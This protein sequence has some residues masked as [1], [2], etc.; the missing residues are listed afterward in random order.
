MNATSIKKYQTSLS[1]YYKDRHFMTISL[2][3]GLCVP[4]VEILIVSA[5]IFD[6]N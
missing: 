2:N 5:K 3:S 4:T 6:I 1:F